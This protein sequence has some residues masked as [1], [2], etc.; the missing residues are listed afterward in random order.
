[1]YVVVLLFVV[2]QTACS[3]ENLDTS[4]HDKRALS[5]FDTLA[6]IGLGKRAQLSSIDSLAGLGLGKRALS[7]F[8]TLGGIGLGKRSF[9]VVK[10]AVSSFDTL[11]GIGLGKRSE[12]FRG[13]KKSLSSFDTLAGIGL[14][15]RS[16]P[17]TQQYYI[18]FRGIMVSA[19]RK[20]Q[21]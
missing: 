21:D 5:S 12:L 16:R 13:D 17:L 3:T 20:E 1:M 11:G 10:K 9:V 7:S 15:K 19:N 6:G 4:E 2:A 8:D 18:P 14:G